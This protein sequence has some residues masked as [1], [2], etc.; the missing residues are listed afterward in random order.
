MYLY[1]PQPSRHIRGAED[2]SQLV[3]DLCSEGWGGPRTEQLVEDLWLYGWD[4]FRGLI[5][6]GRV[7]SARRAYLTDESLQILHTSAPDRDSVTL[8]TLGITIP[9]F[10]ETLRSGRYDPTK[11]QLG[12]YYIGAC[13]L[14]F[15]TV[16]RR[17]Q[18]DRVRLAHELSSTPWGLIPLETSTDPWGETDR[19]HTRITLTRALNSLPRTQRAVMVAI[20]QGYT[21]TE[22]ADRLNLTP[23]A[24]E[25]LTYRA[26]V[27]LRSSA[28]GRSLYAQL[29]GG[30]DG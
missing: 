5:R 28:V 16:A 22:I 14:A 30:R 17:W 18:N 3:E 21:P 20:A 7:S 13:D 2:V 24:I 6:K 29:C 27:Q 15:I 19:T 9:K 10:V 26:R 4:V 12:T 25:G 8:D 23:R 1:A 11:S